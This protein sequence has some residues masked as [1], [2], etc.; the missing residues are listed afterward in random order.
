MSETLDVVLFGFGACR[1]GVEARQI[2]ASRPVLTTEGHVAIETLLGLPVPSPTRPHLLTVK[3][4]DR[5]RDLLIG[6]P[7][8]MVGLAVETIHPLPP[9]LAARTQL[10]GLRALAVAEGRVTL[11]F[12]LAA[13]LLGANTAESS[14]RSIHA[15]PNK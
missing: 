9:L 6:T 2:R 4:A 5:D 10:R 7:V 13:L 14:S 11:L 3:Q 15:K 1:L 8:E 12:D